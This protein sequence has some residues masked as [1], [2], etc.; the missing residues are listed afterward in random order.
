MDSM[1][2]SSNMVD[3]SMGKD[4]SNNMVFYVCVLV[5]ALTYQDHHPYM[6]IHL[7]WLDIPQHQI[8]QWAAC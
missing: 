6:D 3:S 4:D 5:V 2:D 1:D 8:L 7:L